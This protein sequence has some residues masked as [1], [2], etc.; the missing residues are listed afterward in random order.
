MENNKNNGGNNTDFTGKGR[1]N[2][3]GAEGSQEEGS[4]QDISNIDQ[5]EGELHPGTT[6]KDDHLFSKETGAGEQ[7]SDN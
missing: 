4:T 1:T 2:N 5:Q 6:S 3:P 7:E